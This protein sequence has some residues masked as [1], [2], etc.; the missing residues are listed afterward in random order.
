MLHDE[1]N[2]LMVRKVFPWSF[3]PLDALIHMLYDFTEKERGV[4]QPL[5][6][7]VVQ[8]LQVIPIYGT[9]ASFTGEVFMDVVDNLFRRRR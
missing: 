4:D 5:V 9:L 3:T 6:Q 7:K 1:L 2:D 8:E